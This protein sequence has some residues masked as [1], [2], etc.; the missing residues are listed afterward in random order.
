M[1]EYFSTQERVDELHRILKEWKGTPHRHLCAVKGKGVD[2]TLFVWEVLKELGLEKGREVQNVPMKET[3]IDYPP[4]R[5]LHSREEVLLNLLRTIPGGMELGKGV[6]PKTGDICCYKF[7]RS[8]SHMAIYFE[9]RIWQ[10]IA[11]TGVYPE[12]FTTK[13][14]RDKL[15]TIFRVMEVE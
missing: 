4:D 14:F 8:T 5:A 3:Y 12:P 1:K 10:S 15:S 13:K 11:K 2:C 7:G 9:G 6:V